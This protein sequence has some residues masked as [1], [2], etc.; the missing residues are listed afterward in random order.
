MAQQ[1][2]PAIVAAMAQQMAQNG[3]VN[4]AQG[5]SSSGGKSPFEQQLMALAMA[6]K[7]KPDTSLGFLLGQILSGGLN[8]WS[9]NYARRGEINNEIM[10]ANDEERAKLLADLA[11]SNPD[12]YNRLVKRL[13]LDNQNVPQPITGVGDAPAQS[14]INTDTTRR[15]AQGLLNGGALAQAAQNSWEDENNWNRWR[16]LFRR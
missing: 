11:K 1:F 9:E 15:L 5:A 3:N 13:G 8:A 2:D 12:Q 6:D 7:V 4:P 16:N 10:G 14:G